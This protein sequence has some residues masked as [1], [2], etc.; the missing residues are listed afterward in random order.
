[1]K[2]EVVAIQPA[3]L[4]A[5][6]RLFI[7]R[8]AYTIQSPK[9]DPDSNKHY[10][11]RPSERRTG[12]PL[13]LDAATIGRH[14]QGGITI[15]LYAINPDTQRCKWVVIDADYPKSLEDLIKLQYHLGQE[16]VHAALESSRRGGHLWILLD[17]P[18]LARECRIFVYNLALRLDVPVKGYRVNGVGLRDGIEIF[19]KH[20]L[21]EPGE[22]G[23]AIRGP[24]GIHRATGRRYWFYGAEYSATAQLAYLESLPKMT[25]EQLRA[26]IAGL[27]LPPGA[28]RE[29]EQAPQFSPRPTG[30]SSITRFEFRILDFGLQLGRL[31]KRGKNYVGRCPSCAQGGHDRSGDNLGIRI[32]DP[33]FYQCYAGC[34]K[35]DIRG[36][37]GQPIR[38]RQSS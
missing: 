33:R 22:Y 31:R 21:I 5:Y 24:L 36:A 23:N 27:E 4:H 26:A 11:Y 37:L 3:T 32:S 7:N 14:L 10:Y 30:Q 18:L 28:R 16:K 34:S 9:P 35:Y 19:P 6:F 13:E 29:E 1:M 12:K 2:P 17:T 25:E 15:G 8:R 20:D 38:M